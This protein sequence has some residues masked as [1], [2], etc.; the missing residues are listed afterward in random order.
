MSDVRDMQRVVWLSELSQRRLGLLAQVRDKLA[1]E[2]NITSVSKQSEKLYA[3]YA[4]LFGR[5]DEAI[6]AEAR[7]L[8]EM[9]DGIA[10]IATEEAKCLIEILRDQRK[11]T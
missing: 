9:Y 3:Q 11:A 1:D 5:M 8:V 7:S 10:E 6:V 2:L 4:E